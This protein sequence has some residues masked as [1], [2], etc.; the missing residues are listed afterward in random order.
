MLGG[1]SEELWEP[2]DLGIIWQA[3]CLPVVSWSPGRPG[4]FGEALDAVYPTVG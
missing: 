2:K 1:V 3:G 4:E